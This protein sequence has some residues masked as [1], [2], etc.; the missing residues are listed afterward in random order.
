MFGAFYTEGK[1]SFPLNIHKPEHCSLLA[2]GYG[3]VSQPTVMELFP[4]S[5]NFNL[6]MF[7]FGNVHSIPLHAEHV[8]IDF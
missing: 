3:L 5:F 1:K 4:I 6:I 8:V 7:F 2:K